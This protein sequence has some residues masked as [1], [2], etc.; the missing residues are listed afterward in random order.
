MRRARGYSAEVTRDRDQL[1][2]PPAAVSGLTRSD[3]RGPGITRVPGS[4]GF[5][6]RNRAGTTVTDAETLARIG[7]LAVPPAWTNVWI[8]ADPSGHIQAT[9]TDSRGRL[10]YRYHTQWREQRDAQK[11]EH[12]LRFA[13][14]LPTLRAA[15][16]RDLRVHGLSRDRVTASAVRLVDV[17]LFRIGGER[18]AELDHHFGVATLL[19]QHVRVVRGAIAFDYTAKEGK[20]RAITVNDPAVVP[21]VRSLARSDNGLG[22]LFCWQQGSDWHVLHS[23]DVSDYIARNAGGHFTAKE[24]RTWN[25]TVL[26]ALL[27]ASAG[28]S[29]TVRQRKS[30]IAGC[31]RGV[32]EL[33]GDTPA[34][35]RKSYVDP[36]LISS[37]ET[38]GQL[39]SV[40]VRPA[41]LPVPAEAELAVARLLADGL[42][43]VPP[44]GRGCGLE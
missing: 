22:A 30:A 3:P 10:Q 26:A 5:S 16:L 21:A 44:H 19:K 7:A 20:R 24:F 17:G 11:F 25:A 43:P 18:Y 36:R 8:S 40:P 35:T 29:P 14:S 41:V 1:Y 37:Y 32:A 9:G 2:A 38:H 6:Y 15:A 27:L 4:P 33:L 39:P 34:V 31:I 23:L 12:M 28:P 13:Q 42:G